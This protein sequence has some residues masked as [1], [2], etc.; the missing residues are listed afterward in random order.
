MLWMIGG[1]K[2]VDAL[3]E[4]LNSDFPLEPHGSWP[5]PDP[6]DKVN[7]AAYR[8]LAQEYK[9]KTDN[10]ILETLSAM[11]AD[12]PNP[13]GNLAN[14][15]TQWRKWWAENRQTAKLPFRKCPS[16]NE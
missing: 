7:Y 14:R 8:K 6:K 2:A 10:V 5:P 1:G 12:P 4:A 9:T 15:K 16:T 13:T 3:L 11:V